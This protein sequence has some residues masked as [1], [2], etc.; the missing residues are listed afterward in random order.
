MDRV[1]THII[2]TDLEKKMVFLSGPRQTGKSWLAK[3]LAQAFER[4]VYLNYDNHQDREVILGCAWRSDTEFLVLDEMHK[5]PLWKNHL[6]GLYDTK[7]EKLRILVT[8]SARLE[9]F[10][11]SGDSLAGRYFMHRL[12]PVSPSEAKSGGMHFS[13]DHFL[14]RGGFPEPLLADSDEDAS[15][16]RRLYLDGLIRD[17]ILSF[18]NVHELRAIGL[19]VDLLR[20]RVSSLVSYE[21]LAADLGISPN[22]VKRYIGILES[23]YIIFRVPPHSNSIA[24]SLLKQPKYYFFDTGLVVG[25]EGVHLENLVAVSLLKDLFLMEDRDGISRSLEFFRTK[26]G[27]EVDFVL[28]REGKPQTMIEV[29]YSD[30]DLSPNL[31]YFNGKYGIPGIQL[32]GD[33]RLEY[34]AGPG[35]SVRRALDWLRADLN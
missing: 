25:D 32:V 30:R 27:K 16:W 22:T 21:N 23:L 34:E 7:P 11:Q 1:Q 33:L 13:L 5:M 28:V 35:L 6:K 4:S 19:L 9:T 3:S 2:R 18:E 8:G 14:T 12:L 10:R 31:R 26:E 20:E 17:D 15:R 29:N 24:R